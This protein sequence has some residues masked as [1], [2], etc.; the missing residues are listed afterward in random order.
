MC[1]G[2]PMRVIE[3]GE[4]AA[5]C[6][7]RGAVEEVS[8]LLVGPQPPGTWLLVHLGTAVRRLDAEEASQIDDALDGVAAALEGRAF[9]HLF[10]DLIDREPELPACLAGS[11]LAGATAANRG[12]AGEGDK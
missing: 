12:P 8:L 2:F 5:R 9:E 7:R 1:V 11:A 3:G 6:E 10:A 4:F